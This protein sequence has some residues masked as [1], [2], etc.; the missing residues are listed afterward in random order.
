MAVLAM[1]CL[2]EDFRTWSELSLRLQI[3]PCQCVWPRIVVRPS[4]DFKAGTRDAL[5]VRQ[6]MALMAASRLACMREE[7]LWSGQVTLQTIPDR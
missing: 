1:M 7:A 3:P 5:S 6:L 4:G 2:P